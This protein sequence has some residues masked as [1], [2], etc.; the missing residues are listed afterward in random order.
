MKVYHASITQNERSCK[1]LRKCIN[2]QDSG[3]V[4]ASLLSL[5]ELTVIYR[6][7]Q[8]SEFK[9]KPQYKQNFLPDVGE[10]VF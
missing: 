3:K 1:I 7:D 4:I 6:E 2:L 10:V 9:L 8:N 5:L